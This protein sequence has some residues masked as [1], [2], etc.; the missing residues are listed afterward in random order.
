VLDNLLERD[1]L[2]STRAVGPLRRAAD[3][4]LIDTSTLTFAAQVEAILAIVQKGIAPQ[5]V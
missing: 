5:I 1:H 2:D 4:L 3:A